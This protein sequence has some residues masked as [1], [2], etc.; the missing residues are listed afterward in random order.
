MSAALFLEVIMKKRLSCL[1]VFNMVCA[2][3]LSG[4]VAGGVPADDWVIE[5]YSTFSD[6]QFFG[7]ELDDIVTLYLVC[8]T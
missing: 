1:C 3:L 4:C 2:M 5:K 7:S 8:S 6:F